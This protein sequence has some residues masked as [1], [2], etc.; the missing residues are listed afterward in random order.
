MFAEIKNL[1]KYKAVMIAGATGLIILG[2]WIYF[3][4]FPEVAKM[5]K[6]FGE[7]GRL[8]AEMGAYET[9]I[10]RIELFKRKLIEYR[11]KIAGNEAVFAKPGEMPSLVESISD[12][13]RDSSAKIVSI[14]ALKPSEERTEQLGGFYRET[15]VMISARSGYHEF[16]KFLGELENFEKFIKIADIEIAANKDLPKRHNCEMLILMYSKLDEEK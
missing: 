16:G 15:P 7:T 4:L 1:E 13:A 10:G 3:L 8:R 9:D 14:T 12:M 6:V 5:M 2:A 11:E